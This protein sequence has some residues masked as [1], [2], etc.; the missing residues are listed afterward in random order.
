VL[1]NPALGSIIGPIV[2][3]MADT[4][5]GDR[6]RKSAELDNVSENRKNKT[7]LT[8]DMLN[9]NDVLLGRG[10][11]LVKYQGN[12]K[13][14]Q[15]VQERHAEYVANAR[16]HAKDHLARQVIALVSGP[17]GRF[18]RKVESSTELTALG[19][20]PN[21]LEQAVWVPVDEATVLEKVKQAFRDCCKKQ[22]SLHHHH[23]VASLAATTVRQDGST[24]S[25]AAPPTHSPLFWPSGGHAGST[26]GDYLSNAMA[27]V[28]QQRLQLQLLLRQ[29]HEQRLAQ[30]QLEQLLLEQQ[31][32]FPQYH[33]GGGMRTSRPTDTHNIATPALLE[34]KVHGQVHHGLV[35]GTSSNRPP[36][37]LHLS[38]LPPVATTD[39]ATDAPGTCL[40]ALSDHLQTLRERHA[41]FERGV[42]APREMQST[43]R[44]S[45]AETTAP[46]PRS[47]LMGTSLL[48][49]TSI[50]KAPLCAP[51]ATTAARIP[52]VLWPMT[53]VG[54]RASS[55]LGVG[56]ADER[57]SL[58]LGNGDGFASDRARSKGGAAS[59]AMVVPNAGDL[60]RIQAAMEAARAS[61][62]GQHPSSSATSTTSPNVSQPPCS[63]VPQ[64]KEAT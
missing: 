31:R 2:V 11:H 30:L 29:Q 43:A 10:S 37:P 55:E 1:E 45:A 20:S 44:H 26:H 34:Y 9:S 53:Q 5:G 62:C 49:E 3:V 21:T 28:Q 63:T 64:S 56:N 59:A 61:V 17:A 8:D 16:H 4:Q 39:T 33:G 24:A 27:S 46:S 50:P 13:F 40:Q 47:M 19:V 41:I 60:L 12:I 18:L 32:R 35:Q 25:V 15:L 14:R 38:C 6:K 58:C 7:F 42:V 52:S 57:P 54:Q 23:G 51:D 22:P 36:D 48:A